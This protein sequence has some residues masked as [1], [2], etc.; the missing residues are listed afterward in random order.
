MIVADVRQPIV[1]IDFLRAH[2]LLV[3]P[4]GARLVRRDFSE[5][6]ALETIA[7]GRPPRINV[8]ELDSRASALLARYPS[9]SSPID[10]HEEPIAADFDFE[11]NTR[12]S[13]TSTAHA[14]RLEQTLEGRVKAHFDMLLAKG[15]IRPSKSP[16]SSPLHVVVKP[17]GKIR[18]TGDYRV[19][20]A[21]TIADKYP[22]RHMGDL[23]SRLDGKTTFSIIDLDAAFHHIRVALRDIPKTAIITPFGLF[24]FLAM[25]FGFKNAPAAMQRYMDNA[26]R[27]L[28]NVY[29]YVDDILVATGPGEDHE[30]AVEALLNR[31]CEWRLRINPDKCLFFQSRIQFLGHI[32]SADGIEPIAERLDAIRHYP[33][34][35]TQKALRRWL[36]LVNY[37]RRFMPR[38]A[39]SL[40]AFSSL[41]KHKSKAV[42][43][44]DD[45]AADFDRARVDLT[46]V[47]R[48]A[49][50]TT[51]PMRLRTDASGVAI[52]GALEQF[53][54]EEW[55]PLGFYSRKLAD[56]E[57]RYSTFDR[58]L[59]AVYATVLN[60]RS[61]FGSNDVHVLTDHQPLVS[62]LT[63][64]G[65]RANQRQCRHLDLISQFVT[66][67]RYVKGADN[68]VADALSRVDEV[69]VIDIDGPPARPIQ[70]HLDWARA[71]RDDAELAELR[72]DSRLKW[73]PLRL[74]DKHE[75]WCENSTGSPRPYIA[76]EHRRAVFNAA[77]DTAH[78]GQRGTRRAIASKY[79]WKG[80]SK[81]VA[82]WVRACDGC[83]R[84][85]AERPPAPVDGQFPVP[86]GRCRHV[87]VDIVGPL[88]SA[89]GYSYILT[90]IDRFSRW[91]EAVPIRNITAETVAEQFVKT[92]VSRFGCPDVVTTDR[93]RQFESELF[94]ELTR[95]LGVHR[96]RTTAYHPQS[97]GIV[98]R[99]HR[100]LKEAVCAAERQ[101]DWPSALPL[102]LLVLRNTVKEDLGVSPAELLYGAPLVMPTDLVAP[103]SALSPAVGDIERF[104]RQMGR[105]AAAT[106]RPVPRASQMTAPPDRPI[107]R[108]EFVYVRIDAGRTKFEPRYR[109]PFRVLRRLGRVVEVDLGDGRQETV[110]I[111]RLKT[112]IVEPAPAKKNNVPV[113]VVFARALVNVARRAAAAARGCFTV[114]CAPPPSG[115]KP[116]IRPPGSPPTDKRRRVRFFERH[117]GPTPSPV[118]R[119]ADSVAG[120]APVVPDSPLS[121]DSARG[122]HG[123]ASSSSD[124]TFD[125]S[126]STN[127]SNNRVFC[128]CGFCNSTTP[129]RVLDAHP[130]GGLY[131]SA[132]IR[133]IS[134]VLP[135]QYTV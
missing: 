40:A 52:A 6:V 110:S 5:T 69:V 128:N 29:N 17:N 101:R 21:A 25:G 135:F 100:R 63:K 127:N 122:L 60:F 56:P 45:L 32:I 34:P 90:F 126:S 80:V 87:H 97:N 104:R 4:A 82:T 35:T 95:L 133:P 99:L 22:M 49:M 108:A 57:T 16:W 33:R 46:N 109:G 37:Y 47:V 53:V 91:P 10:T 18:A 7:G 78:P 44:T 130:A 103:P 67:I 84:Y 14:R 94:D 24:E 89:A 48:L 74:D 70:L 124:P 58:E 132:A 79:V 43:W 23:M 42:A 11:I 115:L 106:S 113:L 20:N 8:V 81:D 26:L 2:G 117:V 51:G 105:V 76:H 68:V 54:G 1:G 83:Q 121:D 93:G 36:G 111:E 73:A 123:N 102:I 31:L 129:L 71:Q 125:E 59:L 119:Y 38:A 61:W 86:A 72:A 12:G 15:F 27:G 39:D 98:E 85:K 66:D 13:P 50:P 92:W 96:I 112:A 64:G 9:L 62:A 120:P 75:L 55:R 3:D 107:D 88:P 131:R 19:L 28:D 134:N 65:D 30:A 41:L 77:H 118:V 114:V 116:A